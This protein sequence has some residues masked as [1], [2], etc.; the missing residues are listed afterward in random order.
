MLLYQVKQNKKM[1]YT[2]AI[3]KRK[4]TF[5]CKSSLAVSRFFNLIINQKEED[6]C[7]S[8]APTERNN[9]YLG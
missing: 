3:K 1:P 7:D 6:A 9:R 8:I 5:C 4:V 2:F